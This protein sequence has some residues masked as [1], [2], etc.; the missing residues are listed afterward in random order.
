[1]LRLSGTPCV[2]CWIER[3]TAQWRR[4]DDDGLCGDCRDAR[5]PDVAPAAEATRAG[6]V[7]AR[8]AHIAERAATREQ[9]LS[10]LR[11]EYHRARG[12]D[13]A[14]IVAWVDEHLAAVAQ[15]A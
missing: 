3:P 12:A 2:S 15:P 7:Q 11:G 10:L 5:A 14:V 9:A 8:I 4:R 13:K 1:M 6:R